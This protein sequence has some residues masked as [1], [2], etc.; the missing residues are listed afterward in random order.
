M[1]LLG[2]K[3]KIL[4]VFQWVEIT[5]ELEDKQI[6]IITR[7]PRKLEINKFIKMVLRWLDPLVKL[8]PT[9]ILLIIKMEASLVR[10]P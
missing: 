1:G 10:M 7:A 2:L 4:Q 8:E 9:P 5:E 6:N 3:I